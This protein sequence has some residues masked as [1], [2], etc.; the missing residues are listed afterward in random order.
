MCNEFR[1]G[2]ALLAGL[3]CVAPVAAQTYAGPPIDTSTCRD[4]SGQAEVDGVMQPL[5]ALACQQPDGTWV[6]VPGDDESWAVPGYAYSYEPYSYE[7]W[8]WGPV[9]FGGA[10]VF[11]DEFHRHHHHHFDHD[12]DRDFDHHFDRDFDH[13]RFG[14]HRN[15][16]VDTPSV[17]R[18]HPGRGVETPSGGPPAHRSHS[19][20]VP[21][22]VSTQAQHVIV[23]PSGVPTQAP[24]VVVMPSGVPAQAGRMS[25]GGYGGG[26]GGHFS[27][28]GG[29]RMGSGAGGH[30]SSGGGGHMGNGA[31]G[32]FVGGG[33]GGGMRGH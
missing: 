2:L 32:H 8:Y 29:G 9:G 25:T 28:G 6:F 21:P 19:V 18:D 24:H 14:Q 31:G 27:S 5:T 10:F 4:V 20:A 1:L 22:G 16:M 30:A 12:F 17:F 23:M 26:E 7:P 15:H 33:F 3:V 11:F 13:D